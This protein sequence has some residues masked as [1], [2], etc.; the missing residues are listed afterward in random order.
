MSKKQKDRVPES[1][2]VENF[3][4]RNKKQ[5]EFIKAITNNEII[6]AAGVPGSGKTYVAL[7]TALSLL[8]NVY[9]RII[10]IKSVTSIPNEEIGHLPGSIEQKM[11]P[12]MLSF[13]GNIDKLCGKGAFKSLTEKGLIEI[14]PIAYIR[15]LS[16]DNSI[17]ICD[18]SQ[19]ITSHSYKSII[20]RIG[21]DSK[22]I[23]LG[24]IEQ[25]DMRK[26]EQSCLKTMLDIFEDS[27]LIKTIWFNDEDCVR[28]PLIP[29][30]ISVLRDHNI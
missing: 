30:I 8:G 20:S 28:N 13:S 14:L 5:E 29:K 18:E 16:I 19:N 27:D 7:A 3:S 11:D 9:K 22:Y 2:R 23:F 26:K 4:P 12:H 15:G 25:V 17:V 1:F 24:D 10:L 6:I 21:T